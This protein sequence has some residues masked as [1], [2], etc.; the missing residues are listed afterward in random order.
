LL[1]YNAFLLISVELTRKDHACTRLPQNSPSLESDQP[2][3]SLIQGKKRRLPVAIYATAQQIRVFQRST[4][5]MVP[6]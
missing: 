6:W 4:R 2:L 3:L 1:F 5:A